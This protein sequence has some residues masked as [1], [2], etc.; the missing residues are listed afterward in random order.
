VQGETILC[1]EPSSRWDSLWRDSQQIMSRIAARN[2]VLFFEPGHSQDRS[3][4]ADMVRNFPNFLALRSRREQENLYIIQTPSCLPHLR[5][6]LPRTVLH[7]TIPAID[8]INT[9]ILLRHVRWAMSAFA[10]RDPILWLY[11]PAHIDM[12]GKC[13]ERLACYFNYDEYADFAQNAH[14]R[15]LVL[16]WDDRLARSVDVIFA[17]S[18]AQTARRKALNPNTYFIPNGVDF[19]LFHRAL[20]PGIPV[21]GDIAA[22]PRPI[23]GFAGWLGDHIDVKLLVRIAEAYGNC[24]LVLVGPEELRRGPDRRRLRELPNVSFLGRKDRNVLPHYLKT[25]DVA[26]MPWLLAGHIRS[27][28]PLKLHEYLAAGRSCVATALPELLPYSSV[29]R[30]A[31][32][33][34]EFI[35]YIRDALTDYRPEA[36]EARVAV[37]RQNTWDHRVAEIY[38]ILD[39]LL[40]GEPARRHV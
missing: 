23:I 27:A 30:I 25:F 8:R 7:A 2:R 17:T 32:T 5:Q 39:P 6:H 9:R 10:V 22:I 11:N 37:A 33:H 3:A 35:R 34:E 18:R 12:I 21:P 26:L 36:I 13:S 15:D 19:E 29:L 1:I 24:H 31:G 40:E 14:I 20:D 16:S 28:Y 38:R 4:V